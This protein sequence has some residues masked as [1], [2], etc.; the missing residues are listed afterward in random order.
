MK[1]PRIFL[2][3]ST[4]FN[5]AHI[6]I[7]TPISPSLH[8]YSENT[9]NYPCGIFVIDNVAISNKD[10]YSHDSQLSQNTIDSLENGTIDPLENIE[11]W[12]NLTFQN[13]TIHVTSI[14]GNFL[15]LSVS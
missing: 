10:S 3:Y 5:F 1:F 6:T 13:W 9:G 4:D 11:I 2:T 7:Q 12:S 14:S 8:D 15:D